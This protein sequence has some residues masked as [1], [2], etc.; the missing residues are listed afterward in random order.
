[1]NLTR[2]HAPTRLTKIIFVSDLY[3]KN[4][5]G[6]NNII[7]AYDLLYSALCCQQKKF[8]NVKQKDQTSSLLSILKGQCNEILSSGCFFR[9]AND[10][11]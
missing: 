7:I 2:R 8:F 10:I 9:P 6:H 11:P 5:F 1:M 3:F 4:I